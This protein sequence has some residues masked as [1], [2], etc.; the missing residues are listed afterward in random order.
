MGFT[1][2]VLETFPIVRKQDEGKCK[3]VYRTRD[4]ILANMAAFAAG[5]MDAWVKV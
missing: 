2:E 1:Q 3:S 4:Q 5:N